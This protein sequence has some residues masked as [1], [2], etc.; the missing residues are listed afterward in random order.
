MTSRAVDVN[1]V[2]RLN[3]LRRKSSAPFCVSEYPGKLYRVQTFS[4]FI[5]LDLHW[6]MFYLNKFA[7][8]TTTMDGFYV[9]TP[10][11]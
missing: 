3:H 4:L 11:A 5:A 2:F 6:K 8:D 1:Y 10:L 7:M 9:L